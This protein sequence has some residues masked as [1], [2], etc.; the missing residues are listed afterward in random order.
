MIG[1]HHTCSRCRYFPRNACAS[2]A[3]YDWRLERT[4]RGHDP[5][6]ED[7][8]PEDEHKVNARREESGP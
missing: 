7:D 6:W 1:S 4:R 5:D 3:C 8:E 2:R